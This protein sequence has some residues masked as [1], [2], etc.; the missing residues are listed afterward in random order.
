MGDEGRGRKHH[1]IYLVVKME[2]ADISKYP[3]FP[4]NEVVEKFCNLVLDESEKEAV[5]ETLEKL[6][7]LGD[8]QWHTY[9]LPS[10]E[11]QQKIKSWLI[12]NW[13][14]NSAE[15]LESLLVISFDFSL[16]K[17]FYKTALDLYQGKFKSEFMSN[18]ENSSGD[19]IDP[20]WTMKTTR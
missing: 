2:F 16:D 6:R 1:S 19:N 14:S 9:H 4:S 20:W 7:Y 8:K 3:E 15:D 13:V 5:Q 11:L 12:K 18:F 17:E 10:K